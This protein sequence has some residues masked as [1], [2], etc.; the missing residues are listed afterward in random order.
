MCFRTLV[1]AINA[2]KQHVSV[3]SYGLAG[4]IVGGFAKIS[5]GVKGIIVGSTLGKLTFVKVLTFMS[6]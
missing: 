3:V 2:Y 4:L 5:M 6:L 1:T